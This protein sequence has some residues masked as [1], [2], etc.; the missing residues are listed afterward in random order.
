M[1][2]APQLRPRRQTSSLRVRSEWMVVVCESDVR[3]ESLVKTAEVLVGFWFVWT[4]PRRSGI[5]A[6]FGL[7]A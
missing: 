7:I 1:P 2:G 3:L 5:V 4:L 6:F